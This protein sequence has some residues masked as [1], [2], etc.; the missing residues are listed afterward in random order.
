MVLA[1][2]SARVIALEA[3]PEETAAPSTVIVPVPVG[4][5]VILFTE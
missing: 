4:V 5:I 2:P 3:L 1:T